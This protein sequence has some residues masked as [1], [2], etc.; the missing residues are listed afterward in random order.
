VFDRTKPDPISH[1]IVPSL[2]PPN[3]TLSTQP[4]KDVPARASFVSLHRNHRS[5]DANKQPQN[6]T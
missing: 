2:S 4:I 1:Q 5:A 3:R 6:H